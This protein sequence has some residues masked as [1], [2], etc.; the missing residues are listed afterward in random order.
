[1][2]RENAAVPGPQDVHR[3]VVLA[4][5]Q[6]VAFDLAVPAQVFGHR[7]ERAHY[8]LTPCERRPIA[9]R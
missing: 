6:T 4:L 7:D 8:L 2:G 9:E 5:P 1:M 3:V